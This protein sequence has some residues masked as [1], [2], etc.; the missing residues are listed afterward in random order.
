[1]A[2][3]WSRSNYN[4]WFQPVISVNI[5]PAEVCFDK[6]PCPILFMQP[7]SDNPFL[8][9]QCL[10]GTICRCGVSDSSSLTSHFNSAIEMCVCGNCFLL[11][12]IYLWCNAD[13]QTLALL[14]CFCHVY[15]E[16]VMF[17]QAGCQSSHNLSSQT[18]FIHHMT[19]GS[20]YQFTEY[21]FWSRLLGDVRSCPS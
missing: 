17:Q 2:G 4:T 7:C 8:N 14:Q 1:M 9:W 11:L 16:S 6:A 12:I 15:V 21:L 18:N 5:Y 13:W 3:W 19:E 10:W 20:D